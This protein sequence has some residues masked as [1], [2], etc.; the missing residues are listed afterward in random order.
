MNVSV[1]RIDDTGE[2]V[3][4]QRAELRREIGNLAEFLL[5]LDGVREFRVEGNGP[6]FHPPEDFG[7]RVIERSKDFDDKLEPAESIVHLAVRSLFGC[8]N[9]HILVSFRGLA[10]LGIRLINRKSAPGESN[11]GKSKDNHILLNHRADF[12][13]RQSGEAWIVGVFASPSVPVRITSTRICFFVVSVGA[14]ESRVTED[15]ASSMLVC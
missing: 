4:C 12:F 2:T 10:S 11:P 15:R 14:A 3:A 1:P 7:T 13:R 9:R 6:V 5:R 8:K